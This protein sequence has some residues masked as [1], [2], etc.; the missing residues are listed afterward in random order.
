MHDQRRTISEMLSPIIYHRNLSFRFFAA[1][2]GLATPYCEDRELFLVQRE[3]RSKYFAYL[4]KYFRICLI[5]EAVRRDGNGARA[6]PH[7]PD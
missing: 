7:T 6:T 1:Y 5:S 4:Q 2:A 3:S